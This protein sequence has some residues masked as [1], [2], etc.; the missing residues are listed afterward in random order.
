MVAAL[1]D[2]AAHFTI[3]D[4]SRKV[5]LAALAAQWSG[6]YTVLWR[7][8]PAAGDRFR[9]GERG[10]AVTWLAT[11]LARAREHGA[12]APPDA[13]FDAALVGR[14]KQFQ[15]APGL[16]PDSTLGPQ[17]LIRLSGVGD[18]AAPTLLAPGQ[19]N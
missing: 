17:T 14:L 12:T 6:H 11:Q 18:E 10:P 9:P 3:G 8:P 4:E 5:A 15:L 1:D 13:V 2:K 19:G 16:I 7:V